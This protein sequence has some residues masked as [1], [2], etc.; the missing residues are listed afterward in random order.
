MQH[1]PFRP[2]MF[3]FCFFRIT[4]WGRHVVARLAFFPLA[5]TTSLK[6]IA[7]SLPFLLPLSLPFLTRKRH[8]A[9]ACVMVVGAGVGGLRAQ[10][11][12]MLRLLGG[13]AAPCN[14]SHLD[15]ACSSSAS[16]G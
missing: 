3:F 7:L 11:C 14:T 10:A 12:G 8:R 15:L 9:R 13:Q 2:I 1:K 5:T 16:S 6:H 4:E